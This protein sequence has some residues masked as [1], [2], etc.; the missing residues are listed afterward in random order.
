M[1]THLVAKYSYEIRA[2]VPTIFI[3]T[4][5]RGKVYFNGV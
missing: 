3:G 4:S 2:I 5:V 1:D